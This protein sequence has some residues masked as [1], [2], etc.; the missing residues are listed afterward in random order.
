MSEERASYGGAVQRSRPVRLPQGSGLEQQLAT[1]IKALGL[2]EPEREWKFDHCCQHLKRAHVR[3][4]IR[5]RDVA[6]PVVAGCQPCYDNGVWLAWAHAYR[7]GRAWRFDF[8]WPDL[9]LACEVEGG[10]WAGGRHTRGAGFQADT[11][12]H[13]AAVLLGWRVLR[14]TGQDV[15][16][17][18]AIELIERA[19]G[20]SLP[21]VME[22]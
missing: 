4:V 22:L 2:P 11:E 16:D 6:F 7:R 17:G 19:L 20:Q 12:K 21:D 1:A 13:N 5:L 18:T 15:N 9:M 14:V 8:A 10:T 3:S